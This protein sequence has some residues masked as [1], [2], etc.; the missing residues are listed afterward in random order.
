VYATAVHV[1]LRQRTCVLFVKSHH[2]LDELEK[3]YVYSLS[4]AEPDYCWDHFVLHVQNAAFEQVPAVQAGGREAA[5]SRD[6]E[7][8]SRAA[9]EVLVANLKARVAQLQVCSSTSQCNLMCPA[10]SPRLRLS[11]AVKICEGRLHHAR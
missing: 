11:S 7:A 3:Y 4:H 6:A 5:L 9:A 2:A 8:A 1:R 10:V